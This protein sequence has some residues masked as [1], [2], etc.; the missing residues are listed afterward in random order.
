MSESKCNADAA[1]NT[2]AHLR[3]QAQ[4]LNCLCNRCTGLVL[5]CI[6]KYYELRLYLNTGVAV[7]NY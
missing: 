6:I 5:P 7:R 2:V 1:N 4:E 3:A